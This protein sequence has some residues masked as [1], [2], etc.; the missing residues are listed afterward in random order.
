MTEPEVL[1]Y[2]AFSSRPDGGNP[3]GIVLGASELNDDAMLR[4]AA[5][6]DF[7][8]TAFVTGATSDGALGI[9]FF[10]PIAEV[11]FCGHATIA[12][13]VILAERDDTLVG[14][15]LTFAT[16]VGPVDIALSRDEIGIRAAFTSIP[17]TVTPLPDGDLT[18]ILDLLG[19]DRDALDPRLPPRIAHAGNPHPVLVLADRAVFDDFRFDP[20]A[21][22]SLMDARGWPATITIAHRTARDR[23]VT[24]NLFPVGR[25]TEDPAT[26]SAAASL[27]A[28]L[29]EL[30]A[31]PVPGRILIDQG[32]HV[33]RPGLLTVDIPATGGIVVSGHAVLI[34]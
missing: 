9:R 1:R 16:P 21:V 8:E 14:T 7:A 33:G 11:P 20:R 2:A 27:G 12:T 17:P 19:L 15:T 30:G 26:G 23:F 28:Y 34:P 13:A 18:A 24:R 25:I 29:R 3:A 5:E 6:V 4:I 31:V 22:R 10:S 32:A